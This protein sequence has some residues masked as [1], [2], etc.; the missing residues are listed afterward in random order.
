MPACRYLLFGT[1]DIFHVLL[2]RSALSPDGPATAPVVE[3]V[4]NY[5][6][7]SRVTPEFQKQVEEDFVRFDGIYKK[8]AKGNLSWASGWVLEDQEHE[9]I[10][11]EMAKCFFIARGWES[12]DCFEQ[13]LQND[14]YKEAIPILFAW[15]APWKMWHIERKVLTGI[16]VAA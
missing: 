9:S 12:M 7:A 15:N 8:G 13:S 2:N 6:P 1:Y 5:F 3:F 10:K 4:Q 16:E 14:A 11:G